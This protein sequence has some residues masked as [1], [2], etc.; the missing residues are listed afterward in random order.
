[1]LGYSNIESQ[2]SPVISVIKRNYEKILRKIES[3]SKLIVFIS[4]FLISVGLAFIPFL[5]TQFIPPL[6]EGHFIMHMTAYPGTSEK[7]SIRIGNLVT[8]QLRQIDGIKSVAQ[9][10][11]R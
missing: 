8:N 6:H 1:M 7:E 5:K 11:G 10:V 3:Q 2:D 4:L 9:W